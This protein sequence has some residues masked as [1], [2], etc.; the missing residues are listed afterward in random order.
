[1]ALAPKSLLVGCAWFGLLLSSCSGSHAA[2]T[3]V[4]DF[5]C[6]SGLVCRQVSSTI[7][8]FNFDGGCNYEN[9]SSVCTRSCTTD[10][11]CAA[12]NSDGGNH[13]FLCIGCPGQSFCVKP[14]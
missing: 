4:A 12:L 9:T 13:E 6:A 5:A 3:C 11:D 2:S 10:S 14:P 8:Q 7:V 1:M